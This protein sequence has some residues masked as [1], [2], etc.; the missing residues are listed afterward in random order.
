MTSIRRRLSLILIFCSITAVVLSAIF[1][2]LAVNETFNKYL[3]NIQDNRNS[4]VVEYFQE[5]YK[6]EK[7]WTKNSGAEMMHEAYMGNYCLTLLD[8]DKNMVWGMNP[9]DIKEKTQMM[10]HDTGKGVYTSTTYDIKVDGKIVG[11]ILIGQYFPVLLSQ[12]DL[13]FKTS[14]NQGVV[15]S[16][17]ITIII[18]ALISLKI[19]KQFSTPIKQVSDTSVDLS[20]G[21]YDS[22]TN[23]NSNIRELNYLTSSINTLGDKLKEQDLLRR[24]LISDISHEIRTPLN[25]LENNLEAMIDGILPPS[26]ERLIFLNDEVVRFGK[27]LN[28]LNTLKLIESEEIKLNN[29]NI[30]LDELVLNVCDD[31]SQAAKA[32]NIE[33]KYSQQSEVSYRIVGDND[34]LKQVFINLLSNAIKFTNSDGIV[35]VNLSKSKSKVIVQIKDNGIGIKKEDIP[36]IFERLYRG[37]KSRHETEGSGIGL[38]IVKKILTLHSANISVE[39]E[40]GKGTIFTVAFN[41]CN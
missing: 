2:N 20:K 6:N 8:A 15:V 41:S 33:I 32:K 1:V 40:D 17:L 37:D 23:I 36:F 31:F 21:N 27:L 10:M 9:T 12:D 39:S 34:K 19:S 3:S 7:K 24:R 18:V 26:K 5:V 22:R 11:Y 38:T 28:N 25:V 13:N 29:E 14:I 35:W 30:F 4:R 16:A